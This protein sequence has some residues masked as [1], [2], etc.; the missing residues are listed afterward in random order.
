MKGSK[1]SAQKTTQI[2]LE[3]LD[4]K[5]TTLEAATVQLEDILDSK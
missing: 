3:R 5:I 2:A 4:E 1:D